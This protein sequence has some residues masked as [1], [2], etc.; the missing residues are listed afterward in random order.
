MKIL[1][2]CKAG[3]NIGMGHLIRSRALASQ[4]L[5]NHPNLSLTF[6]VIGEPL[7]ERLLSEATFEYE[8]V[9]SEEAIQLEGHYDI[10]FFDMIPI[11]DA[12]F[13]RVSNQVDLRV[14]ISPVFDKLLAVD[15]FFNRTRYHEWADR[16][17]EGQFYGG[18]E[19]NIIQSHCKKIKTSIYEDNLDLV[20]FPIALI[21]GGGDAANQTLRF[22]KSMKD[23]K[24]PA[25]F[26]VLLGEGYQHSYNELINVIKKDSNHE[27]ILAKTNRSMWQ[28]LRNCIL[29]ILPGGISSYE[30]VYA[31]LPTINM[32]VDEERRYLIQELEEQQVCFYNGVINDDNLSNLNTMIESLYH[33]RK[34]LL[35]MH[36]NS[37][38]LI[39]SNTAQ[40]ILSICEE[41]LATLKSK[42]PPV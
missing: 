14:S 33:N 40:R 42:M 35:Q 22:L 39:P 17:K 31:G 38:H 11:S 8:I 41:K 3:T 36:M 34:D 4:L 28:I 32:L 1:F 24:V 21:M 2:L 29:A 13:A 18:L 9:E 20:Q 23:C 27:I 5:S 30:A 6:K 10:C 25:T 15:L 37:K 7:V 26:W 16:F 12:F 19:Y